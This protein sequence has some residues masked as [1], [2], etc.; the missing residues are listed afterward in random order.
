VL[1]TH[2]KSYMLMLLAVLWMTPNNKNI[3][4]QSFEDSIVF[5]R[6][7]GRKERILVRERDVDVSKV[8]MRWQHELS[9]DS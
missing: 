2:L 8:C 4:C 7:L 1:R 9:N 6:Y 5:T 3:I